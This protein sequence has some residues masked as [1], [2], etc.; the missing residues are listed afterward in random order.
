MEQPNVDET[1]TEEAVEADAL[2]ADGPDAGWII[3][4]IFIF[5]IV[6]SE[7]PGG[8]EGIAQQSDGRGN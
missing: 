6:D 3:I 8:A 5:G 1:G 7:W 4:D 2:G